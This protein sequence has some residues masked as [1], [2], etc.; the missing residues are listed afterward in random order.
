MTSPSPAEIPFRRRLAVVLS[1]PT[2]YYSPWFRQ[3]AAEGTR[4]LRV[5]YLWEFGVTARR[6]PRFG[7]TFKWD[8]DLLSG[9]EHEFV[10][11]I[12]PD[13]G[14]HHFNGLHNPSL[15]SRLAAWQPDLLLVFGYNWRSHLRAILWA[16]LHSVPV[17]FRGDSHFLGRGPPPRL[18]RLALRMLFAQFA[19]C[20]FV[21]AA[22]RDYFRTLGVP[23]HRLFFVPHAVDASRFNPQDPALAD[24]ASRL[25]ASLHLTSARRVVLFAGKFVPDKQ[26]V[27]LLE[28]FLNLDPPDTVLIFIGDGPEKPRLVDRAS[29]A[30]PGTVHVLPFANQSEI[31]ARLLLADILV[32]PSSGDYETWGLIVNEAM[33]LGVP[34]LVSDRVGCQQDLV[35]D[36]ETGWVFRANQPHALPKA[37]ARALAA[38]QQDREGFRAR[39][40]ARIG[41]YTFEDA[42]RGLLAAIRSVAPVP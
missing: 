1:H 18:R 13:P 28:A 6:D 15:P 24:Q 33:H 39:V 5:F 16:R 14:T 31:P 8:V 27:P 21:G 3:I 32:L 23:K 34:A 7:T 29:A 17:L 9:Y 35:T 19:G 37:L 26:P 36:S 2:Q 20:L 25:R 11:N 4:C 12:A 10:P 41:H 30:R 22:N 40:L 38:V 42:T